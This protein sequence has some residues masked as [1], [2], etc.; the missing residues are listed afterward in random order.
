MLMDPH[1]SQQDAVLHHAVWRLQ[2]EVTKPKQ[3]LITS[4]LLSLSASFINLTAFVPM[5]GSSH[6]G[7][8]VQWLFLWL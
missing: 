3:G 2:Q 6:I 7:V 5:N 4:C 1:P 8:F